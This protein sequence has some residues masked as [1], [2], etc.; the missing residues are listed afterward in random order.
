[1][2]TAA[3][4]FS[5]VV[6]AA[7]TSSRMQGRHKLLLPLGDE[8][9]IRRTVRALLEARPQEVVV[10]T[11]FQQGAVGE[12]LAGLPVALHAN[13]RFEEGQMTSAAAG[14]AALAKATDAVMVCL[15]DMALLTC[16]DYRVLV[17]C[18]AQLAD[19]SILVPQYLGRRGNPVVIAAW[20][21]PEIISGRRNLGCRKLIADHPQDV[22]A[23]ESD[24]DRYVTDMDTPQDYARILGRLGLA[25]DGMKDRAA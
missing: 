15:G 6:L 10:V 2:T 17:D 9:V 14:V 22:F 1:M 16:A 3:P 23:Y 12:A 21:V 11:G 24:H 25:S 20:R 7:G 13:P 4:R 8:P 18:H 19:K 5:A